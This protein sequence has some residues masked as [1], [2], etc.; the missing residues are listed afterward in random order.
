M[1]TA[2]KPDKSNPE[3]PMGYSAVPRGKLANAVTCLEMTEKPLPRE[4]RN[5]AGLS[6]ERMPA[7]DLRTYRQLFRAIGEDWLWV[8]RLVMTDEA[9]KAIIGDPLVEIYVLLS[10]GRQVGMLELDFRQPGQC[11][12]VFFGLGKSAIG[13]G[14]G[15][16][17]MNHALS[18]AWAHPIERLWVHTCHFDH[19]N[20]LPFYQRSGFKPYAF[21]IEVADDPRLTGVLP[22]SAAPHVPI[23]E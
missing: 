1:S 22:R 15:R 7:P 5:I 8:S 19:P 4:A 3:L 2:E 11:E 17:L 18:I 14:A 16:Y 20:A 10:D 23:L 9:L 21:M 13:T 12:L 6:L